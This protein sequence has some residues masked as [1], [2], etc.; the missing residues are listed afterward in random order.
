[1]RFTSSRDYQSILKINKE[2]VNKVV[3]TAVVIY[4]LHQQLTKTNSYGEA[5]KKTWYQGVKCPALIDRQDVQSTEALQTVDVN[6][7]VTICFLRQEL[8]DRG[9]Y[10]EQGD[11]IRFDSS[12]Y[13]INT[14]SEIQ[15]FG[16]REEYSHTI[17]CECHLSRTTNLQLEPP[18]L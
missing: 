1:M 3:D 16:G 5:T 7:P 2:L 6:Q 4:K 17:K 12:Y 15:L 18:V 9:V 8:S 14:V 10:P 13:E 11:I